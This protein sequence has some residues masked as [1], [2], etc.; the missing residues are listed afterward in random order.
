M[1]SKKL[2]TLP[3][4]LKKEVYD[5]IEFLAKREKRKKKTKPFNFTWEGGLR[6]LKK[7]YGSVDLQHESSKWR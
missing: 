4:E 6:E 7:E 3:D 1:I 5:F 2:D